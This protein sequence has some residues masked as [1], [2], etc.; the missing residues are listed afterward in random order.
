MKFSIIAAVDKN[1][2]IGIKNRLPWRLKGELQYFSD[3]T[4]KA[5]SGKINAVI[6]GRKTWESL[7]ASSRPLKG[8]VNVVLS[9]SLS[10]E[11]RES[12]GVSK[13]RA[14]AQMENEAT[15]S[16]RAN[17]DVLFVSSFE[18]AFE[19]LEKRGDIDQLFVIGGANIY[20]QAI[21]RPECEKIYLT[22]VEGEFECDSF[23][24]AIPKGFT[25]KEE[26]AKLKESNLEYAFQIIV[27]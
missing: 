10:N 11:E 26:S 20:A 13:G 23:F 17:P 8:R 24:P 22:K 18:E 7:P 2:G 4:T 1:F 16:A 5:A 15:V 19:A 21:T 14:R 27:R 12:T 6:M 9:K 3:V 25:L